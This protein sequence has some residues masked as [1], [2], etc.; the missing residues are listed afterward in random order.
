V[1]N[2][3]QRSEASASTDLLC[4]VDSI[5]KEAKRPLSAADVA[6]EL[7]KR[8]W[9]PEMWITLDVADFLRDWYGSGPPR[10]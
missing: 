9:M 4:R 10:D 5:L 2:E 1:T 8:G 3:A 6:K 7:N